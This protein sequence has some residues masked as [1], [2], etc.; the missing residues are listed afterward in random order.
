MRSIEIALVGG[1]LVAAC[2]SS[3]GGL[4]TD[5]GSDT[6]AVGTGGAGGAGG[7]ACTPM[8]SSAA[9]VNVSPTWTCFEGACSTEL[10]ACAA[11]CV[12]NNAI[13]TALSCVATTGDQ[14]G[15]F[16]TAATSGGGGALTVALCLATAS[17]PGAACGPP[18][19]GGAGDGATDGASEAA[20]EAGAGQ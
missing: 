18:G 17:A 15:C 20:T 10:T 12:C 13:L 11:D 6:M 19:D 3:S 1:L 2:S 8:G 14:R 9:T 16:T 5:S 4:K 7:A